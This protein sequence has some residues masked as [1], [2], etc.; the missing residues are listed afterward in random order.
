MSRGARRAETFVL[1]PR[2]FILVSA[3][4][5]TGTGVL[6]LPEDTRGLLVGVAGVL[7]VTIN[8]EA[9]DGLPFP[10]GLMPGFFTEVRRDAANT[11]ANIWAI[12]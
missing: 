7:N 2:D 6:T 12:L 11:A 1:P 4:A 9:R 10:V 8:G 5:P 3:A